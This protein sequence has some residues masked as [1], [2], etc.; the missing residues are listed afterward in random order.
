MSHGKYED[1]IRLCY[2]AFAISVIK[3]YAPELSFAKLHKDKFA[4]VNY[5][6]DMYDLF[7][8]GES[9]VDIGIM[10]GIK[11]DSA[12]RTTRRELNLSE[13]GGE[14]WQIPTSIAK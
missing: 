11:G 4:A 10:F 1:A 13:G 6:Q 2:G 9:W 12:R 14:S 5:A 3:G 8:S 7:Q